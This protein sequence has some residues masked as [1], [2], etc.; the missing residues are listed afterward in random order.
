MISLKPDILKNRFLF[1]H[2][3]IKL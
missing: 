1:I 3:G 2:A